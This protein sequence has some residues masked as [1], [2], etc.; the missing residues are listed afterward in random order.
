[1]LYRIEHGP[2][3]KRHIAALLKE[4]SNAI[5]PNDIII[6]SLISVFLSHLPEKLFSSISG[7]KCGAPQLDNIQSKR[8]CNIQL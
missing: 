8:T 2:R 7:N 5:T 3:G 1:M 4:Y 6:Y